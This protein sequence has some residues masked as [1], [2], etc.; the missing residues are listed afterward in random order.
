MHLTWFS[1]HWYNVHVTCVLCTF[2]YV[3]C[4]CVIC[5]GVVHSCWAWRHIFILRTGSR[6]FQS[7]PSWSS[8]LILT[9]GPSLS[10]SHCS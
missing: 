6:C 8:D 4:V 2:K 3:Q 10:S 5:D 7:L 1:M 9:E